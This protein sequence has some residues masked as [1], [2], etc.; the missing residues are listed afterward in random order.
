[1]LSFGSM[2]KLSSACAIA[3]V[4]VSCKSSG[5]NT[6]TQLPPA[7]D[8]LQQA[9]SPSVSVVR[10]SGTTVRD[11]LA[12]MACVQ[13]SDLPCK[14]G[15]PIAAV[16]VPLG[17]AHFPATATSN[18]VQ[19]QCAEN[20]GAVCGTV[21]VPLDRHDPTGAKI[22]IHFELFVHWASGPAESAILWNGGGPGGGSTD[23]VD[24]R[25]ALTVL[26]PDLDRHDLLLIDD[27]G[28]GYSNT[29]ICPPLQYGTEPFAQA[30]ASCAAQLGPSTSRYASGEVPLDVEDVLAALGYGKVDYY[31]SSAGG[32]DAVAYLT[33]FGSRLRSLV[34]D[35]PSFVV[36]QSALSTVE[37]QAHASARKTILSC[38]YS[39]TCRA[40]HD[41][42]S[43]DLNWLVAT[44]RAHPVAGHAYDANGN[45]TN[46]L[47]DESQLLF[48]IIDN[49]PGNFV[50]TGEVLAAARSL[51]QGDA[52]PLL[53]LEAESFF[54]F[55]SGV[56]YGDPTMFSVGAEAAIGCADL[57]V[58]WSWSASTAERA[59]Q[60]SDAVESLPSNAFAPFS[61]SAAGTLP[62]STPPLCTWWQIPSP[63]APITPPH[64]VYPAV[65][66]IALTGDMDDTVPSEEVALFTARIPGSRLV[67]IKGSA[68]TTASY[69]HCAQNLLSEFLETLHVG[70]TTCGKTPETTFPAVGRFPIFA[71]DASPAAIDPSRVNQISIEERGA[72]TVAVAAAVDAL[73]RSTIGGGA[74]HCLR[75][76]SFQTTYTPSEWRTVLSNCAFASDVRTNGTVVWGSLRSFTADL[77]I[78]GPGTAPGTIHVTGKW[79]SPGPVGDF[80]IS[81]EIGGRTV[82]VLLPE[83]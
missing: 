48:S 3:L 56:N 2:V 65:P 43:A 44:L 13:R 46:V 70:D 41:N 42:P 75:A 77:S 30:E 50:A 34:M 38:T 19:V 17:P 64:P 33:R 12:R 25:A 72:V 66:T 79:E 23:P 29:I 7:V 27:R 39:P 18:A 55:P 82:A 78:S 10:A 58:P 57:L 62:Y 11:P 73:K 8:T 54:A 1:M 5:S 71:R 26:G 40:D 63:A 20:L 16:S 14:P 81:G 37:L 61:K 28:T 51:H 47:V 32:N 52:A 4:L 22:G 36:G 59:E 35:A 49:T 53:R 45:L 9:Q 6:D 68:H 80:K 74:D 76:G 69:S 83:A 15:M 24:T 31:V 60:Y 67:I 21:S